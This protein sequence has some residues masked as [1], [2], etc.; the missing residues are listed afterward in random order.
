[1]H[2]NHALL[3]HKFWFDCRIM[4][5]SEISCQPLDGLR[6][7][8]LSPR[9]KYTEGHPVVTTQVTPWRTSNIA[10]RGYSEASPLGPGYAMTARDHEVRLRGPRH[11]VT[12]SQGWSRRP[13][14]AVTARDHGSAATA[15]EALNSDPLI[16]RSTRA[17]QVVNCSITVSCELNA[18]SLG[19]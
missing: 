8:W 15:T 3:N 17:K 5:S 12:A 14:H 16:F 6:S 2:L 7:N 11:A 19:K 13:G 18:L 4:D 1:M 9:F 10:A